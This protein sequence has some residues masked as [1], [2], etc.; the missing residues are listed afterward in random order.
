MSARPIAE[1]R[2]QQVLAGRAVTPRSL[3]AAPTQIRAH[4]RMDV[5]SCRLTPRQR[6]RP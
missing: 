5:G 2:R 4:C 3:R 1:L 6:E